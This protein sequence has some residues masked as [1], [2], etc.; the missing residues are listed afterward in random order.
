MKSGRSLKRFGGEVSEKGL[1]NQEPLPPYFHIIS[2]KLIK[3]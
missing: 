2:E 3:D 1:E